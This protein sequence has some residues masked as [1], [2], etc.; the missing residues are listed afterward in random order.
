MTASYRTFLAYERDLKALDD[1][2]QRLKEIRDT[3]QQLSELRKKALLTQYLEAKL[4][5]EH[6]EELLATQEEE[7]AAAQKSFAGETQRLRQL[8]EEIPELRS[9]IDSLKAAINASPEGQ[10]YNELSSQ[11]ENLDRKISG[12]KDIGLTLEQALAHRVRAARNWLSL[13]HAIPLD[14]DE[15]IIASCDHALRAVEKGGVEKGDETL[16]IL[17]NAARSALVEARRLGMRLLFP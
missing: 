16:S 3:F 4:Y 10:L 14:F 7:L 2:F 17:E 5:H 1:Q 9:R 12:R 13:I 6:S 11:K 8:D 15:K